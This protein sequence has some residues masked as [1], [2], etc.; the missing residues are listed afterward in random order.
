MLDF[1]KSHRASTDDFSPEQETKE[2]L[3]TN[4]AAPVGAPSF[5]T[6]YFPFFLH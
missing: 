6:P 3:G 2:E 5:I 1:S 4:M